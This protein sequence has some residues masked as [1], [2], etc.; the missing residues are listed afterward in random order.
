MELETW[1]CPQTERA[2]WEWRIDRAYR[3]TIKTEKTRYKW[4]LVIVV[5]T[6]K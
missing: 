2:Q 3:G 5:K 4:V 6:K 1:S